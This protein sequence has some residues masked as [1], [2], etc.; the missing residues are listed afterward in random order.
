MPKDHDRAG[1]LEHALQYRDRLAPERGKRRPAMID[2]RLRD[3]PQNPIGNVGRSG[4]LEEVPSA[5][6]TTV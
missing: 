3:G 5:F 4:N 2:G 1:G 6:H